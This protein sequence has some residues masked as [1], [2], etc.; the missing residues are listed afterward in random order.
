MSEQQITYDP[1][2]QRYYISAD[3]R[4]R[5][6]DPPKEPYNQ[7]FETF[8]SYSA[9]EFKTM[10]TLFNYVRL[11]DSSAEDVKEGWPYIKVEHNDQGVEMPAQVQSP[12]NFTKGTKVKL[13]PTI[14]GEI[15]YS[16]GSKIEHKSIAARGQVAVVELYWPMYHV[17]ASKATEDWRND[18]KDPK[19]LKGWIHVAHLAFNHWYGLGG[20]L[21]N[22]EADG[23][24]G[25]PKNWR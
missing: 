14:I 12:Q 25:I 7:I 13:P 19:L 11:Q 16:W 24:M 17:A 10:W 22:Q 15:A 8:I 6:A 5:K 1:A 18:L 20:L 21:A 23:I 9:I 4:E 3:E 2:K